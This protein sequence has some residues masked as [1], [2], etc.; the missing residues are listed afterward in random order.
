VKEIARRGVPELDT[1][2]VAV[3]GLNED[4]DAGAARRFV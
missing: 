3:I 4:V 2:H 1:A